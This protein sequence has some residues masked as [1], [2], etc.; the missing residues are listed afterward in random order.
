MEWP[1][2]YLLVIGGFVIGHARRRQSCRS[3]AM[4]YHTSLARLAIL[5]PRLVLLAARLNG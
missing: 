3:L 5:S 2:R 1:L 4:A